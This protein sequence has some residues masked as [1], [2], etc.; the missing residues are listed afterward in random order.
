MPKKKKF[1][2]AL[3]ELENIVKELESGDLSLEKA[4]EKFESGVKYSTYC[5][6]LLDKAEKKVSILMEDGQGNIKEEPFEYE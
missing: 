3:K 1:E 5:N 2:D 4:I 6:E